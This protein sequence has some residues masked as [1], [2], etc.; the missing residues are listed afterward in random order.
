MKKLP[1]PFFP[2]RS[3]TY[4]GLAVLEMI[5]GYYNPG[6]KQFKLTGL[7]WGSVHR[8]RKM[9]VAVNPLEGVAPGNLTTLLALLDID[10]AQFT[11]P[12]AQLKFSDVT[13]Y[14]D[15]NRPII[16]YIQQGLVNAYGHF[17][18]IIGYGTQTGRDYIILHDPAGEKE[19]TVWYDL[20]PDQ[21]FTSEGWIWGESIVVSKVAG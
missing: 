20:F 2:Q 21:Y 8:A 3:P 15:D 10:A 18:V 1:V 17:L 16:A 6:V 14:I 9:D 19:K 7:V 13:K 12:L 4:C 5:C 11:Y